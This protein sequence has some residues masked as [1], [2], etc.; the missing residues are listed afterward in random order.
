MNGYVIEGTG[1]DG[2]NTSVILNTHLPE[3]KITKGSEFT[4]LRYCANG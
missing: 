2:L 1:W 4:P 3:Y